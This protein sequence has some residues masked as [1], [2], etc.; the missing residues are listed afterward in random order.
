M[1]VEHA[2]RRRD[3]GDADDRGLRPQRA[4]DHP[5]QPFVG[6]RSCIGN[7]RR[8]APVSVHSASRPGGSALTLAA[9]CAPSAE[10]QSCPA[11]PTTSCCRRR[12]WS[13]WSDRRV[14]GSRRGRTRTSR[15][16][17]IVS[18]DRLRG[19]VG[20][21]EDDLAA[22]TDAF[23]LLEQI[24]A[25][26]LR[27]PADDGRRHAR[28]RARARARRGSTSPVATAVHDRRGRVRDVRQPNAGHGTARGQGRA[29]SGPVATGAPRPRAARR[30]DGRVRSRHSRSRRSCGPR[31]RR[32]RRAASGL[33]AA[34][35]EAPVGLRFGLQIPAFAWPGGAAELRT[36]SARDRGRRRGR[37]LLEH[38]GDGPLPPDPDVRTGMARHARELHDAA[39][40]A[41]VTE[42][43]TLGTLV[44]GVTYRNVAHLGKIVGDP[45][46][47]E[48]R[49]RRLRPRARVVRTQHA[50]Y[51][52]DFPP[53]R[54]CGPALL[55]D[56]LQVLP[57]WGKGAPPF[58]G[59][60]QSRCPTRR[61]IRG[62][63]Q[64]HV[65]ILVGGNGERRTLRLAA[66]YADAC[67]IIGDVDVVA[68]S[69]AAVLHALAT[70]SGA[71]RPASRSNATFAPRRSSVR[72][73]DRA[74]RP[75]ST[76]C[77]RADARRALRRDRQRRHGRR[78][79]RPLPRPGRR[80]GADRDR[81]PPRSRRPSPV[82]RFAPVIAAFR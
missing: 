28:P 60:A 54:R 8:P 65:P 72:G 66:Q 1:L 47:L 34:Q 2:G 43:V 49:P 69:S 19:I 71:I 79:H 78:P 6:A 21:G 77:G 15:R 73:R 46:C 74:R 40:L 10:E 31:R 20:D 70:T 17:Q 16:R 11:R 58:E 52:W 64:A 48:R 38:L 59:R 12:A 26:R 62:P 7:V 61:A 18:S 35:A 82:E 57:L 27:P 32:L 56:T 36:R 55:E 81:Q 37:G 22:S 80:R 44:T 50:A 53:M 51:G 23:A 30:L 39:F 68:W 9:R 42:R 75:S 5:R 63:L 3:V 76:A 67:N 4:F 13:C 41:G 29:R 14:P 24:V 25:H 33:A 45:R